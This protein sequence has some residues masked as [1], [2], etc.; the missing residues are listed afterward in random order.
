MMHEVTYNNI[1]KNNPV[2]S[3]VNN[4]Q[5]DLRA[6]VREPNDN[7]QT[8]HYSK[9]GGNYCAMASNQGV[10]SECKRERKR[11]GFDQWMV[12]K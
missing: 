3:V 8:T 5:S 4:S 7:K 12:W 1:Y 9:R 6:S 2:E 11:V 10:L